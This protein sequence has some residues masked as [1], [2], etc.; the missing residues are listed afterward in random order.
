[1]EEGAVNNE[2]ER[3]CKERVIARSEVD[4][5]GLSLDNLRKTMK[6]LSQDDRFVVQDFN[7]RSPE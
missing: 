5:R 7:P 2:V 4:S 6:F 3:T 1:M